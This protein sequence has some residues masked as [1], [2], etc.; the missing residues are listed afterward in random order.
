MSSLLSAINKAYL[1]RENKT[2]LIIDNQKISY[3]SLQSKINETAIFLQ[4]NGIKNKDKIAI[5]LP[6]NLDFI[7]IML[8][9]AKIG[10]AIVPM[11]MS[12][13]AKAFHQA[14]TETHI[15]HVFCWHALVNTLKPRA[16]ENNLE[17]WFDVH[18]SNHFSANQISC[19]LNTNVNENTT[20]DETAPFILTMTSGSTGMPKPI[21]LSQKTKIIRANSAI[22]I[23]KIKS[24]DITLIATPLY[25]SLAERLIIVSLLSG[26][27]A[28][29][30]PKF[31]IEKWLANI[32]QFRVTFTISVSSQLKQLLTC[33][34]FQQTNLLSL[35]CLVS[36][37]ALLENA[38]KK[39]LISVLKC[40]FHE[41]YGTSEIAIAT[42]ITYN[43]QEN[44]TTIGKAIPQTDIAIIDEKNN[45]VLPGVHGEIV[46]KTAMIFSEYYNKPQ[47]TSESFIQGF[48]KTGD[49]GKLDH[50]GNLTFLGRKKDLIITGGINVYPSD[51]EDVVNSFPD[52]CDCAAFTYPDD[53]L[54]EVV[55][56]ALIVNEGN[57]I[58]LKRLI[59]H[60]SV[61][62]SDF[63]IPRHYFVLDKLPKTALGKIEKY[64][65]FEITKNIITNKPESYT[66]LNFRTK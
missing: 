6:N 34:D 29:L 65:L 48:F 8:A 61:E 16:L 23:Y 56:I 18:V 64:K 58:N 1:G 59:R 52:I 57:E 55:A 45:F 3:A 66:S 30:M 5:I 40:D 13:T 50:E 24:N 21:V 33:K 12:I 41:C 4:K 60:C 49:L 20:I 19:K 43:E 47:L 11:P 31:T 27:T 36:S 51:V 42:N 62:L 10:A 46:C 39:Q 44:S 35:R 7:L 32:E 54:G 25:H 28:V 63:Q 2:A 9:A 17:S 38:V 15:K 14:S 26:G 37:S 22:K 53:Y